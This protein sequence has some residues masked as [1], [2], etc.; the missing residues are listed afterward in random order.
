MADF[1]VVGPGCWGRGASLRSALGKAR[2]NYPNFDGSPM[3]YNAYEV[4][5]GVEAYVDEASG[6][7]VSF[8]SPGGEKVKKVREVRYEVRLDGKGVKSVKEFA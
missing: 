2:I 5:E 4:P 8:P 6:D 7:L 1:I 3:P